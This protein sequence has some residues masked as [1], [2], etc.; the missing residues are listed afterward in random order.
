MHATRWACTVAV[1]AVVVPTILRT[2][3]AILPKQKTKKCQCKMDAMRDRAKIDRDRRFT[4]QLHAFVSRL[5]VVGPP[6]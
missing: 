1:P 3:I 6:E 4:R 5:I 2:A